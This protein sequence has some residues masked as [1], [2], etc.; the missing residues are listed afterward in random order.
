M[1]QDIGET[2]IVT[3]R[4]NSV[5]GWLCDIRVSTYWTGL[6]VRRE[7]A[8]ELKVDIKGQELVIGTTQFGENEILCKCLQDLNIE[9]TKIDI[10]MIRMSTGLGT[11]DPPPAA[12][13][14]VIGL[15]RLV[16]VTFS[17]LY[18]VLRTGEKMRG[19]S[20]LFR[21]KR[22]LMQPKRTE[23]APASRL[24]GA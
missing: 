2:S 10:T 11:I 24:G 17:S 19:T 7:I 3:L 23:R 8:R 12:S 5:G 13:D 4:V 18:D 1:A 14:S 9:Q 6:Q 16:H 20:R 21:F 22:S 15:E